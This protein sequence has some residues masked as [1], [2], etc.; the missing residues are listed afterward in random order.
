MVIDAVFYYT[1]TDI[2]KPVADYTLVHFHL[3]FLNLSKYA[4]FKMDPN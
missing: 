4:L 3:S 1:N 2:V